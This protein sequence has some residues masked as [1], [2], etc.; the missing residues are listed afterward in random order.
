MESLGGIPEESGVKETAIQTWKQNTTLSHSL[1]EWLSKYPSHYALGVSE[2]SQQVELP[3]WN[4]HPTGVPN[5]NRNVCSNH[6]LRNNDGQ[7]TWKLSPP[8][9]LCSI[10]PTVCFYQFHLLLISLTSPLLLIMCFTIGL[11]WEI[12]RYNLPSFRPSPLSKTQIRLP[13]SVHIP[14]W[15][16]QST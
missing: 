3:L 7:C 11:W 6:S 12:L 16:S 1:L 5:H 8:S 4:P 15:D 2:E 14:S 13:L 10:S 9:F